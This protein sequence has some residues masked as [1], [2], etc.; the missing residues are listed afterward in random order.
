MALTHLQEAQV[1]KALSAYC[2]R[3]PVRVRDKLRHDFRIRGN[4]VE[5]FE[6]R[7]RYDRPSE[8]MEAPVAKFRY[9]GTRRVWEL[10]CQFRDLKWHRYK[11]RPEARSFQ[12]LLNEVEKDPTCIFWG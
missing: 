6:V 11:P 5:L 12:V 7:P 9:V 1:W 8:W 3:V 4:A 10:Y 2:D